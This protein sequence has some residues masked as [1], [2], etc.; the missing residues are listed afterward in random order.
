VA[1]DFVYGLDITLLPINW[2]DKY[3]LPG[4]NNDVI[5]D[6]ITLITIEENALF[7]YPSDPDF[8]S[9]YLN[10][11]D[12][13]AAKATF[14]S[15]KGDINLF[16]YDPT[17]AEVASAIGT[18][19]H[20]NIGVSDITVPGYFRLKVQNDGGTWDSNPYNLIVSSVS[21][22]SM[23]GRG[24]FR[25]V[26]S[27]GALP[28][29]LD[30][31]LWTPDIEGTV[32]HIYFSNKMSAYSLPFAGLDVD[33]VT[34]YGPETTTINTFY[35][36]T[37]YYSIYNYSGSPDIITSDAFV[38][39]FDQFGPIAS[40]SVPITGTGLWWHVYEIDDSMITVVDQINNISH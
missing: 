19:D 23:V 36:G 22:A 33:D 7:V 38:M 2:D 25:L 34:S 32:H 16:L 24:Q 5:E 37:Y 1:D 30:S 31:H 10:P 4:N 8:Y 40:I 18:K 35:P 26:L 28:T 11:G 29:D 14:F 15:D 27:W 9:I 20:E 13:W 21:G 17:G 3:D 6:A 12:S 39:A